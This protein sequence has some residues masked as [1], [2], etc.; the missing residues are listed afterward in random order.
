MPR[1]RIPYDDIQRRL[2]TMYPEPCYRTVQLQKGT[3]STPKRVYDRSTGNYAPVG[4]K[5]NVA[6]LVFVGYNPKSTFPVYQNFE[7]SI[8]VLLD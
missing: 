6:G 3:A 1:A 4:W 2:R 5:V 7:D 8:V